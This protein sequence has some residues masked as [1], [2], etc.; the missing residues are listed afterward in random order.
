MSYWDTSC[1][2]KLYAPEPDSA[3]FHA[4]AAG[5]RSR[6]VTGDFARLELL[7]TLCRKEAEGQLAPGDA[8]T[9][10]AKFDAHVEQRV[11]HLQ[12][13]DDAMRIEFERVIEKCL[14]Q[15]PPLFVRTLD[16]LHLAAASVAG[17]TEFVATDR[18]LRAAAPAVGFTLF[19]AP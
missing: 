16:A 7:A 14:S 11:I 19:P 18:R 12:M 2:V 10:L 8:K 3:Q 4:Y 6:P 17:E 15:A 9:L 5:L 13:L 1:L